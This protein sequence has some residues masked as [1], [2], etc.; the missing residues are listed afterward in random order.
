MTTTAVR[1]AGLD[2]AAALAA[3]ERDANLV[4]LAH[5][6][7]PAVHAF[8]LAEVEARWSG[9]LGDPEVVVEVVV[10]MVVEAGDGPGSLPVA[11]A[12]HDTRR[13]RHLAVRPDAWGRGLARMLLERAVDRIRAGGHQPVLWCLADNHR[14]RG[15]Y[16][17]LG[18]AATGARRTS[19][20]APHPVELEHR[21]TG[22][23]GGR[24]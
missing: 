2:D 8:P 5:V 1:R 12:A 6:F 23:P 20:F 10:E 11:L 15:L 4:A 17:H 7:D 3:L 24:P 13:V 19:E 22:S 14:A 16:E 9:L 18:R 21:L